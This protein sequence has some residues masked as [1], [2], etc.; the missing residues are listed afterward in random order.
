VVALDEHKDSARSASWESETGRAWHEQVL[1]DPAQ[2]HLVGELRNQLTGFAV[3]AGLG[4]PRLEL[5]R[6][7]LSPEWIGD[8]MA[9][10]FLRGLVDRAYTRHGAQQLWLHVRS[11]DE[12]GQAFY[13]EE[14]FVLGDDRPSLHYSPDGSTATLTVMTHRR[15]A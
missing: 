15:P 11:N 1:E 7:V 3:L 8:G 5:R 2:E 14:G 10:M 13:A 4:T 12:R 9:R 6:L